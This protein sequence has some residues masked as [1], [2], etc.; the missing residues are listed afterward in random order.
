VI[1]QLTKYGLALAAG[2]YPMK[3]PPF[4]SIT[5]IFKAFIS[6]SES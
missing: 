2:V 4:A 5:V 1:A 6:A 3:M